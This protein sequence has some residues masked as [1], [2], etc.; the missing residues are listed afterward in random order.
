[1]L[2]KLLKH[3]C[4]QRSVTLALT[5]FALPT[6]YSHPLPQETNSSQN[7]NINAAL[8]SV[9]DVPRQPLEASIQRLSD[10]LRFLGEPL[11]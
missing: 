3:L 8:D 10:A 5:L 9:L 11:A 1:M 2:E 6:A 7:K 4:I